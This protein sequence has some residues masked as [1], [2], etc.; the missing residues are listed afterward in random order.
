MNNRENQQIISTLMF[1][2][3][4]TLILSV[5]FGLINLKQ[6]IESLSY[7]S[8]GILTIFSIQELI[9]LIPVVYFLKKGLVN[10]QDLKLKK[11]KLFQAIGLITLGFIAFF[12]LNHVIISISEAFNIAIP[13]YGTQD[14]RLPLFGNDSLS[15][16]IAFVI[17]VILA[18]II[19]ELLFRGLIYTK[20]RANY[21]ASSTIIVSS[22]I[23]A[24]FHL[25]LQIFLPLFILGCIIGYIYEKSDSLWVPILFHLINN[26]LA[27]AAEIYIISS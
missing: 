22:I 21:G 6:I 1:I 15:L 18:P 7:A 8:L 16:P 13:G 5:I 26:G 25:E 2:T 10:Y 9:L 19:E 12:L 24:G 14:Q 3:G 4:S 17:L 27:F 20:L 11:F 23:F